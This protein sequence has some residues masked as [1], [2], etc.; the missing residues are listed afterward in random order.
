[1]APRFRRSLPHPGLG[2]VVALSGRHL[3]GLLDFIGIGKALAS[4]GITAEE[5]PPA[6]LQVELTGP[7]R[8][9]DM[10]EAWMIRQLPTCM[11]AS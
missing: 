5:A 7:F 2:S 4:Q 6:L 1:M 3:H 10:L 11:P 9:E 8:D